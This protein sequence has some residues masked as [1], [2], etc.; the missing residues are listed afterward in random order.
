MCSSPPATDP[1]A[2]KHKGITIFMMD[3]KLPGFSVRRSGRWAASAP[4]SPITK[5]SA[6][7]RR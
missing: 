1:D 3:T 2:P 5:T 4:T 6:F 7:P